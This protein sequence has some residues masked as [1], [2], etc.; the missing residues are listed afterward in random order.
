MREKPG[1]KD[2]RNWE[3]EETAAAMDVLGGGT[4]PELIQGR[5]AMLGWLGVIFGEQ[6]SRLTAWEQYCHHSLLINTLA[7]TFSVAT[8]VPVYVT[9]NSFKDVVQA[10]KTGFPEKFNVINGMAEEQVGRA[11]MVGFGCLIAVESMTNSPLF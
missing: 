4:A 6:A 3:A 9:A 11:A 7:L 5:L 10:S 1:A 8:L 2:R